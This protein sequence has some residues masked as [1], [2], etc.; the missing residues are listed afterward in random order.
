MNLDFFKNH[1]FPK[2]WLSSWRPFLFLFLI[3]FIVYGKSL[4]FGLTYLDDNNLLLDHQPIISS[5]QNLPA[6]FGND[7]FFSADKFYYRPLL[8]VSFMADYS[9]ASG[10]IAYYHLINIFWH[11]LVIFGVFLLLSRLFK[12]KE[13]AFALSALM[14]VQPALSQAVAWIPGR[15]DLLLSFF[16]VVSFWFFLNFLE[17]ERIRDMI[18]L[19]IFF[20][21]ALLSKETAAFLPFLFFLYFILFRKEKKYSWLGLGLAL[22]ASFTVGVVW[23]LLRLS[24]LGGNSIGLA[25]ALVSVFDNLKVAA[26]LA[27]KAFLPFGLSGLPA[28]ADANYL[29]V[30]I[31]APLLLI[32]FLFSKQKNWRYILFGVSWFL[33]FLLP[34]LVISDAA[35]FILEHRLYLPFIGLLITAFG[36]RGIREFSWQ[37][38]STFVWGMLLLLFALLTIFHINIFASRL[39]FW[40][41]ATK[42]SPH[43]PLAWRNLGAM[44]YLDANL[45]KAKKDFEHSLSL[46]SKEVMVHNNLA[47]IYIDRGN[48]DKALSE[49]KAELSVNPNYDIAL[50]NLGRVY[51]LK[52]EYREAALAWQEV[53]RVNPYNSDAFYRLRQLQEENLLK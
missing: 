38:I 28:P 35:P 44:Y 49:L 43:S 16:V 26:V 22:A 42:T 3:V 52:K 29:F 45:D 51:Y 2:N 31:V 20:L 19:S 34:P 15:N 18:F 53:L 48:L 7:V 33:I 8:N 11:L 32:L 37:K 47:A 41:A 46:N 21:L 1:F 27:A 39:S 14:A 30:F 10:N 5:W 24:A 25:G 13:P 6:V 23:F 50:Y 12:K 36:F 9:L 40:D 17:K 4:F